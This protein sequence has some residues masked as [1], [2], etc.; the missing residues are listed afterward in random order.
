MSLIL[1]VD[2]DPDMVTSLQAVV[3]DGASS[4][5]CCDFVTA[6]HIL[7]EFTP[8]LLVTNARLREYNG[9]HLAYL[10]KSRSPAT[11]CVIYN[12]YA[13]LVLARE[14]QSVGGFFELRSRI[15][16]SLA[17]Y[18]A[19]ALPP[20]DRRNAALSDR[21]IMFRGGRRAPDLHNPARQPVTRSELNPSGD[22]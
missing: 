8:D 22:A 4:R 17:A 11:R 3:G 14:V 20:A 5:V 18:L 15:R 6:R 10:A 19:S 21:R 7:M 16:H 1:L 9:L 13:D 12:D 2:P